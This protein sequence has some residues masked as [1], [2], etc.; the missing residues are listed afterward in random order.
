MN[1]LV[2]D[3]TF[4]RDLP[5]DSEPGPRRRQVHGACYSRVDPTKVAAP[6]LIS[7]SPECAALL[8]LTA[9]DVQ[10]PDFAEVFGGNRTLP[11]MQPYAAVYGGHQFGQ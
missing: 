2:F 1:S 9:A 8:G 10:S 5:A 7:W 6:R 4:V 3:N 11:G